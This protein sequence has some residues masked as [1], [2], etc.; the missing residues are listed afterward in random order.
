MEG[1][2]QI[3][4]VTHYFDRIGVAVILLDD[5]VYLDDWILI[6]GPRTELE[7]QVLSMQINYQPIDKGEPGEEVAIKVDNVVREG[8][9]V[10]LIL[11][12]QDDD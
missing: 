3:G 10:Y 11:D 1:Y 6:Y 8:D 4:V 12:E 2:R 7:Q 9:E 5:E